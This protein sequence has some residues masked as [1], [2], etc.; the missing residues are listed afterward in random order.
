[1]TKYYCSQKAKLNSI[2]VL[3]SKALNCSFCNSKTTRFI[4]E[5][6][7]RGLLTSLEI[8]APL[9]RIPFVGPLLF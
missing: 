4:K 9:S 1:M 5:Q 3:I 8:K 2:E 6:E 7:A